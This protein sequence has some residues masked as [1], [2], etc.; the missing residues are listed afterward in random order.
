MLAGNI[1]RRRKSYESVM[2]VILQVD[3]GVRDKL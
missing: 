1:K 2:K 3:R